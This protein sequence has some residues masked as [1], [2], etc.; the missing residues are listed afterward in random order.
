M[1]QQTFAPQDID[2][3]GLFLWQ[4]DGAPRGRQSE[5][6]EI[7]RLLMVLEGKKK[8]SKDDKVD[9]ALEESFPSSDP[10]SYN[11]GTTGLPEDEDEEKKK[12]N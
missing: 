4:Q 8:P 7:A 2:G 9:E 5:Y 10:P 6:R 1:E 12:K 3:R 11:P